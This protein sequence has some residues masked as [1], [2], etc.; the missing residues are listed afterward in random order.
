MNRNNFDT[1]WTPIS[2]AVA[3]LAST[4]A[5]REVWLIGSRANGSANETSD[6]DLMV[7]SDE[8]PAPVAPRRELID[9]LHV[10]P[11]GH[12][13][14]EGKPKEFTLQLRDFQWSVL[15]ERQ[16]SYLG[17]KPVK[18]DDGVSRDYAAPRFIRSKLHA[19]LIWCRAACNQG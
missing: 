13:L 12:V 5:T 6:W 8:E 11:S 16:A 17:K 10:G 2:Q 1:E 3:E 18:L 7:F 9:V 14:L 15:A 19:L 4:P